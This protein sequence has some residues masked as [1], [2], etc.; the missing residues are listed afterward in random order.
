MY[1]TIRKDR[2]EK[3]IFVYFGY[4]ASDAYWKRS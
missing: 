3:S 2:Q 1:F 4:I